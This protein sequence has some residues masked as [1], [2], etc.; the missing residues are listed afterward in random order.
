MKLVTAGCSFTDMYAW[1]S[2]ADWLSWF[3]NDYQNI[4]RGGSGNTSIYH[5][6]IGNI[7][8][9]TINKDTFL[10]IQWSSCLRED[11]YLPGIVDKFDSDGYAQA[12][13]V[14]NNPW[15]DEEFTNKYFNPLQKVLEHQNYIYSLKNILGSKGIKYCMTFMM[16]PRIDDFLGEPYHGNGV[17]KNFKSVIDKCLPYLKRYDDLIDDHFTSMS[18]ME[19]MLKDDYQVEV[20][21]WKC[22]HTG[23]IRRDGHPSPKQAFRYVTNV[24]QPKLN[25]LDFDI[26]TELLNLVEEWEEFAKI[27]EVPENK[28]SPDYWPTR[29]YMSGKEVFY[30][31]NFKKDIYLKNNSI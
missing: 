28:K 8:N 22:T 10:F 11:R 16:D 12:G 19:H 1:P 5:T 31:L 24:I 9:G 26:P 23:E 21:G 29:K 6:V 7:Q 14:F 17:N 15:Y 27:K 30:H 18:I 25:F 4:A 3:F 2:Y 20:F 13:S